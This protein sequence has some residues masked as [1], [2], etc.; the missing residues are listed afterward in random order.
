MDEMDLKDLK[1][2]TD[3]NINLLKNITITGRDL[4]ANETNVFLNSIF[5]SQSKLINI[6]LKLCSKVLDVSDNIVNEFRKSLAE[7]RK[8]VDDLN[9]SVREF[10]DNKKIIEELS[11][12][13]NELKNNNKTLKNTPLEVLINMTVGGII[14][15]LALLLLRAKGIL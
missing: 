1:D 14:S 15:T 4:T 6:T 2:E 7:T 9:N 12:A 13:V 3:N 10:K 8:T 11:N 5:Y